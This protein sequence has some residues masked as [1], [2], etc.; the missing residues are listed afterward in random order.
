MFYPN[1][2][3]LVLLQKRHID[4]ILFRRQAKN[5]TAS[6][7]QLFYD[8]WIKHP[9]K[10]F[11]FDTAPRWLCVCFGFKFLIF[12]FFC[13]TK[14]ER[15]KYSA[16]KE[17]ATIKRKNLNKSDKNS[18]RNCKWNMMSINQR[19]RKWIMQK[20]R[21]WRNISQKLSGYLAIASRGFDLQ[22][23]HII[24]SLNR[25]NLSKLGCL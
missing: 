9:K 17:K 15:R 5:V 8:L 14:K 24:T 18:D 22:W 11:L 7:S 2:W 19:E 23:R 16:D 6:F 1:N 3:R 4:I 21:C 20:G 12:F 13:K 25:N 10:S